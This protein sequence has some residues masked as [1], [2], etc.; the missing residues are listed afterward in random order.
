LIGVNRTEAARTGM[1]VRRAAALR[2][3]KILDRTGRPPTAR[4][5]Q[6]TQTVDGTSDHT[7]PG[8]GSHRSRA[9]YSPHCS[10]FGRRS[11]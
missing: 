5:L 6:T 11:R 8:A 9:L 10:T 7:Y 1:H 2:S 3:T 4:S